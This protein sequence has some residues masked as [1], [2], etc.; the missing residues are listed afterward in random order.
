MEAFQAIALV[1]DSSPAAAA[2]A[3]AAGMLHL[4]L[5]RCLL[6]QNKIYPLP[7]LGRA[8]TRL[9]CH[10]LLKKNDGH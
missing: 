3:S 10:E 7:L 2:A 4:L 6:H 8:I 5:Q 9:L 1:H